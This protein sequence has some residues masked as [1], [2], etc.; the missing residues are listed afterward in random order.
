MVKCGYIEF[1]TVVQVL[2][3]RLLISTLCGGFHKA[4]LIF[5]GVKVPMFLKVLKDGYGWFHD[6]FFNI[7]NSTFTARNILRLVTLFPIGHKCLKCFDYFLV[8]YWTQLSAKRHFWGA[9]GEFN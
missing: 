2:N 8:S 3:E 1:Y 4:F 7:V 9:I 6:K 5:S